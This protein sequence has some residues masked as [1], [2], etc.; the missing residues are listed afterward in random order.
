MDTSSVD[1]FF[2]GFINIQ[3]PKGY[4]NEND[5]KTFN[6]T[7]NTELSMPENKSQTNIFDNKITNT[8]IEPPSGF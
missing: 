8:G 6:N 4:K 3:P 2:S 5:I 7:L 1:R